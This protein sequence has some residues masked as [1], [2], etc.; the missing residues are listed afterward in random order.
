MLPLYTLTA[1]NNR[2]GAQVFPD[3]FPIDRRKTAIKEYNFGTPKIGRARRG[4]SKV[5]PHRDAREF[6]R[7]KLFSSHSKF[8]RAFD[9]HSRFPTI[10]EPKGMKRYA[11]VRILS[12]FY[13]GAFSADLL[14]KVAQM[15]YNQS[16]NRQKR[17]I[18]RKNVF[19]IVGKVPAEVVGR[20]PM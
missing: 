16:T 5:C 11:K 19:L 8:L 13:W 17:F 9:R 12:G 15:W 4:L 10:S 14:L 1:G 6:Y 2:H 3:S 18:S 7:I 20:K